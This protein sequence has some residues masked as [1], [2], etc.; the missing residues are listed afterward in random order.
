MA[1]DEPHTAG[2]HCRHLEVTGVHLEH[3]SVHHF[4]KG[5]C[6]VKEKVTA[7]SPRCSVRTDGKEGVLAAVKD[8][9]GFRR[10]PNFRVRGG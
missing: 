5:K 6:Q 3:V 7:D 8:A 9:R 10:V 1:G 2:R 4:S